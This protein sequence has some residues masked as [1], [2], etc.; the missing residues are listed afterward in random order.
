MSEAAWWA[1]KGL[2]RQDVNVLCCPMLANAV[3]CWQGNASRFEAG[4]AVPCMD[5]VQC[6]E[7]CM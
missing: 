3:L 1:L 4:C 6:G 7:M 5:M 2:A